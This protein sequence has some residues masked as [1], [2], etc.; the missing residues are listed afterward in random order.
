MLDNSEI[1]NVQSYVNQWFEEASSI[2][3]NEYLGMSKLE[4]RFW[5]YDPKILNLLVTVKLTEKA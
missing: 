4:Y 2:P 1:N 3:L 5:R